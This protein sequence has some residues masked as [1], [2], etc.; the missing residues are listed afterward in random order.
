[1]ANKKYKTPVDGL[2]DAISEILSDYAGEVYGDVGNAVKKA[3]RA[4]VKAIR[5]S[6]REKFGKGKYSEGWTS[7]IET[8]TYS[9]QGVIYN[10]KV[11]GLPHLLEGRH[12]IKNGMLDENGKL[13]EFGKTQPHVHIAPINQEIAN[14][15]EAEIKK[16]LS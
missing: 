2:H 3:I 8:N 16:E 1:M 12:T 10:A 6:S 13:K 5:Q 14:T 7:Q 11:P 4:G 15:F 9:A